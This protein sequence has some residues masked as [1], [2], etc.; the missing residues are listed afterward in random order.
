MQELKETACAAWCWL[1][2]LYTVSEIKIMALASAF[3][4]FFSAVVGGA[5]QQIQAL[6]YL[7]IADYITGTAVGI[8][9]K[10]FGSS[11][12]FKGLMKKAAVFA[13]VAFAY[14]VDQAMGIKMLRAMAI[15]GFAAVEA[16][17][18]IENLDRLGYGY[19]IPAFIRDKLEQIR[20]EKGVKL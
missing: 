13:A 5:D 18:I 6:V 14:C 1:I 11:K 15:F 3:G 10:Q 19:Y 17:S 20:Q 4:A 2:S 12:G 8:K 7:V 16:T 9:T